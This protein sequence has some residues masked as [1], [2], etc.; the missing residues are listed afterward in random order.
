MSGLKQIRWWNMTWHRIRV[1]VFL[2]PSYYT[3]SFFGKSQIFWTSLRTANDSLIR[4][5]KSNA[6]CDTHTVEAFRRHELHFCIFAGVYSTNI[7]TD[8]NERIEHISKLFAYAVATVVTFATLLPLPYTIVN[9]YVLDLGMESFIL[10]FPTWFAIVPFIRIQNH[11][12]RLEFHVLLFV[13]MAGGHLIGRLHSRTFYY[14]RYNFK[15]L[16]IL[17]FPFKRKMCNNLDV[18]LLVRFMKWDHN[19][20]QF[21]I[22][23]LSGIVLIIFVIN[24]VIC[25]SG[26]KVTDQFERFEV[27]LGQCKWINLPI[28]LQ[29]MYSIFLFDT[30]QPKNFQIGGGI[31]CT[32]ETFKRVQFY[33]VLGLIFGRVP[34]IFMEMMSETSSLCLDHT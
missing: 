7:Y 4:V 22:A 8:A 6:T 23:I 30:Q 26:E 2:Q 5:S 1:H 33:C 24:L 13:W 34:S 28:E 19:S 21:E 17:H 18:V 27:E 32:C 29:R 9:Y 14:W 3:W 11:Q 10:F 16:S 25:V 15:W 12:A 20:R 31:S